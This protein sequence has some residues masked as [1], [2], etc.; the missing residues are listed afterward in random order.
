MGNYNDG[1]LPEDAKKIMEGKKRTD[2]SIF[3]KYGEG[4]LMGTFKLKDNY[5]RNSVW[6]DFIVPPVPI[7]QIKGIQLIKEL[8]ENNKFKLY[9]FKKD[10][11]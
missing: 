2:N 11:K 1:S 6:I 5:E 8:H 4:N 10:K 3:N 9:Y 7:D